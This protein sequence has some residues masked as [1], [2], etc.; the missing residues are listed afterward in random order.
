MTALL[1]HA[2]PQVQPTTPASRGRLRDVIHRIRLAFQETNY[3]SRRV[4]ELRVPWSVDRQW[5]RK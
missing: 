1:T 5:H 3:V 2:G 4:V